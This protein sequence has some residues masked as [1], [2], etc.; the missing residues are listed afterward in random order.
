MKTDLKPEGTPVPKNLSRSELAP[1]LTAR[2]DDFM[3]ATALIF[4][5]AGSLWSHFALGPALFFPGMIATALVIHVNAFLALKYKNSSQILCGMSFLALQLLF[6]NSLIYYRLPY[7]PVAPIFFLVGTLS[8]TAYFNK[9][10]SRAVIFWSAGWLSA[11]YWTL[12]SGIAHT[13]TQI[14]SDATTQ[15]SS[16]GANIVPFL[17]GWTLSL[18]MFLAFTAVAKRAGSSLSNLVAQFGPKNTFDDQRIQASKMQTL[19]ELTASLAHEINNPLV[20]LKGYTHQIRGEILDNSQPS[21]D[22]LLAASERLDFNVNRIVNIS[23]AL[24]SFSR[25]TSKDEHAV[26][27]LRSVVNEALALTQ[28]HVKSAGVEWDLQ[29]PQEDSLVW[30]N[31]IQLGQLLVNLIT[32]ARDACLLCERRKISLGFKAIEGSAQIWVQDTGP[33]ISS[34]IEEEVYRPFF[35]TKSAG[36]GTG[37]G[38]YISRMIAERHSAQMRFECPTDAAGRVLGT[39]FILDL[40]QVASK[41]KDVA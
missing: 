14:S 6:R 19:G 20:A 30:G 17:V 11:I 4:L 21:K 1:V 2:I 5:S 36:K 29:L 16:Q 34:S 40:R 32:N 26:V 37:L 33:G 10:T 24:G 28:H 31:E 27:S 23:K 9:S 41:V 35:T 7:L 3:F 22:L 12:Q 8:F 18:I 25:D 38:L 15:T 13:T 39:R